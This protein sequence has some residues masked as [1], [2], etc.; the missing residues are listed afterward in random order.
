MSNTFTGKFCQIRVQTIFQQLTLDAVQQSK[1]ETKLPPVPAPYYHSL[2]L[3]LCRCSPVSWLLLIINTR[4]SESRPISAGMLP[5]REVESFQTRKGAELVIKCPSTIKREFG[6]HGAQATGKGRGGE[7]NRSLT[8]RTRKNQAILSSTV[9]SFK[10][11]YSLFE[12]LAI[13]STFAR[14]PSRPLLRLTIIVAPVENEDACQKAPARSAAQKILASD[15]E[16]S[17]MCEAPN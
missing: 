2:T 7:D 10:Y 1:A 14:I 13:C 12:G 3:P 17:L 15:P 8:F 16:H 9:C 6:R 5:G 11:A 4:I